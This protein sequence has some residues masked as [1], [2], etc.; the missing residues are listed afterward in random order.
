M[1]FTHRPMKGFLFVEAE[2]TAD[3]RALGIRTIK[4]LPLPYLRGKREPL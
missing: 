4:Y 2:A 1:D 3:R